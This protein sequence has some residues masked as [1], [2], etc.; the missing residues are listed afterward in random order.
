MTTAG[1]SFSED[2]S[3]KG[4]GTNTTVPRTI[5]SDI[6]GL[7]IVERIKLRLVLQERKAF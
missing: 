6:L 2:K 1:R 4:K 5:D 7:E 3:V